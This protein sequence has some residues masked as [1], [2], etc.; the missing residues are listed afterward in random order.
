MIN[1]II[2]DEYK[3]FFD[4]IKTE[5]PN[6]FLFELVN[7]TNP[8]KKLHLQLKKA[9]AII[10]QVNLSESQYKTARKLRIIQTLSS[11]F[12]KIDLAKAKKF[13]VI[14]ANN[15]GANAVSVAEHVIMLILGLYRN[16]IFQHNSLV[17]GSWNNLKYQN[18]EL[19][20]KTLGIFGMGHIGIAL[21]KIAI[22]MGVNVN[23]FDIERKFKEEKRLGLKY[24]FPEELLKESDIV[25]YHLPKT[26][27]TYQIINQKSLNQM[28]KD[29]ILINTSRGHIHDENAI[30][31][32]ISKGEIFGAGLDVFEKEPLQKNSPLKKLN[33]ILLTPH[34]APSQEAYYRS[35]RNAIENIVLVSKGK[36]PLN[37]AK[38]Y[39]KMTKKFLNEFPNVKFLI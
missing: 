23:Y 3:Y 37:S 36:T 30:F 21:A 7:F 15:N 29:A 22:N 11:G 17:N 39:E 34:S 31:E 5:A 38:D 16:L 12:D 20:G 14:I 28:R 18:R 10:G 9:D 1:I 33:N 6:S 25:S 26:K 35:I 27:Y 19:Q 24:I 13:K 8:E 4:H 2:N 32:A